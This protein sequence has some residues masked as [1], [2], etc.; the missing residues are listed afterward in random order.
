MKELNSQNKL[1]LGKIATAPNLL[2]LSRLFLLPIILFFLATANYYSATAFL[3]LSWITDALDGY[4][5]RR[6]NQVTNIGK[7]LDHLVDKVSVGS[8][9]VV[10]VLTKYFPFW[11]AGL[12]IVRDTLIIIGSIILIKKRKFLYSSN[13]LGKLAGFFFALL[14]LIYILDIKFIFIKNI[15]TILTSI[16][17]IASFFYYLIMYLSAFKTN[18]NQVLSDIL[19]L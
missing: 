5:A 9:F 17:V 7:I 15:I 12:I 1:E 10:L 11:L 19:L 13:V 3:V 16:L 2:S 4:I 6:T 8:I 18:R 14:M